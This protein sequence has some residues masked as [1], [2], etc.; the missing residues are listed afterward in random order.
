MGM[1]EVC[2]ILFTIITIG[3]YLV[4][5]AAY[6]EKKFEFEQ[7]RKKKSKKMDRVEIIEIEKPSIFNTLPI[8]I[9]RLLWFF[10]LS[11]PNILSALKFMLTHQIQ[12]TIKK[13]VIEEVQPEVPRVKT[14]RKRNKGFAIPEGPNFETTYNPKTSLNSSADTPVVSGGLWTDDDLSELIKLVKKYPGGSSNRWEIIAESLGRSIPEVTY[15]AA[16]VKENGYRLPDDEKV[17]EPVAVKLKTRKEA[18]LSDES[19]EVQNWSQEQQKALE[20]ALSKYPKGCNDRWDRIA[21]HVPDKSKEDCMLRFK[22]LA[23]ILRK[24]KEKE[25]ED[26]KELHEITND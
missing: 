24:Q 6:F 21:E 2:I 20:E 11:L 16:K 13:P 17:I 12:E 14:V 23:E 15:M 7:T 1:I 18:I 19:K 25:K 3:Q 22:Y 8:Q 5:W 9:P 10:I 26:T 4:N